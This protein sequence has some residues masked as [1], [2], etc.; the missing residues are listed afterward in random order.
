MGALG[1]AKMA[2]VDI[3]WEKALTSFV[4]FKTAQGIR[5]RTLRDYRTHVGRFFAR[6][7]EAIDPTK[8]RACVLDYLSARVA[9]AT[10]NLRRR[11][12]KVFFDWCVNEGFYASN[13]LYGIKGRRAEPRIVDTPLEAIKALLALCDGGTFCGVR[14]RALVLLQIDTGIR[15]GEA[16]QL[17]PEDVDALGAKV[18]V[19]QEV[20]KTS[21]ART[22]PLSVQ[23]LQ[24]IKALLKVRPPE[25]EGI[26]TL[27]CTEAGT[28]FSMRGWESRLA[29]LYSPKIGCR[30]RP[31]DLRHAHALAFIRGGGNIFALQKEMGHST[32]DMTK[33]YLALT[34]EDIH[35]EHAKAS[36]VNIVAPIRARAPRK[37]KT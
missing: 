20:S 19:R 3:C 8:V 14:D 32:L 22:L 15:P 34:D 29:D 2:T 30:I 6:F 10:F 13:P 31:Y 36:P 27:F 25:W 21:R 17:T 11:Y 18:K 26:A 33:R 24:A 28:R 16:L 9:P 5:D 37:L 4:H 7:P 35:C 23:T 12:L 1:V